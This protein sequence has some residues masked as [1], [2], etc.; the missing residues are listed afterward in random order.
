LLERGI[1]IQ[2]DPRLFYQFGGRDERE[3]RIQ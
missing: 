1:R 3:D 2:Q